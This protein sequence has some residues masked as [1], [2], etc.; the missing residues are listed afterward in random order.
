MIYIQPL[1][2]PDCPIKEQTIHVSGKSYDL[3][4]FPDKGNIFLKLSKNT[5]N[6]SAYDR[7]YL[8]SC[9]I[10]MRP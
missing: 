6:F 5:A 7:S 10:N 8:K 1:S 2:N 4:N 9:G 3:F